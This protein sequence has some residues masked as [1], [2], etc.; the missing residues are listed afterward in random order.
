MYSVDVYVILNFNASST[1]YI[2]PCCSIPDSW[3]EPGADLGVE[4]IAVPVC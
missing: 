3:I 2:Q 1:D 4:A